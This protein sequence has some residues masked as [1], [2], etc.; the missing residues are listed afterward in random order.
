[1]SAND[2]NR[3]CDLLGIDYPLLMGAITPKPELPV[4]VTQAGGLGCIEGIGSPDA[5]RDQIRGFR[6][7]CDGPFSVNF[8]IAFGSP[9]SVEERVQVA[10]EERVP[11][12]VTSAG[13]PRVFTKRLQDH[14]IRVGHVVAEIAHARKAAEAGVDLLIAEPTE[15]GGYRGAN[16]I[17]MMVLIPGIARVL[18][19]I[20]LVAAGTVVDRAGMVA[21]T[22][23][24]AEGVWLGT[25]LIA[26]QEGR[27]VFGEH[28]QQL[29]LAADD[30]CTMSAT[31]KTRPR[32]TRPEFVERVLG[33]RTKRVQMGQAAALIDDI[34][35][36]AEVFDE[37]FRDAGPHAEAVARRLDFN[38]RSRRPR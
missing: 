22:A 23:L 14:G 20:P 17:S 7:R 37:L 13:S 36:L 26:T 9:D 19:E 2:S 3:V 15:S 10:I 28:Y 25:R 21:V 32:V 33:T 31:G 18:P 5:L 8:P 12:V 27:E 16:E 6:E 34:P 24:G 4:L 38:G 1:M 11:V 35:S 29:I 30:V